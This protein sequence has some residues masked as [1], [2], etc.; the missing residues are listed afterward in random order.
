MM[1]KRTRGMRTEGEKRNDYKN[2]EKKYMQE[3]EKKMEEEEQEAMAEQNRE[4]MT[5]KGLHPLYYTMH[6]VL[7]C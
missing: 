3:E 7:L 2:T 4:N 5:S 1:W 6:G